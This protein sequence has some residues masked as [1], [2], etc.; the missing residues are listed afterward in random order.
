MRGGGESPVRPE[1]G[2]GK[3]E[4]CAEQTAWSM[5]AAIQKKEQAGGCGGGE[6]PLGCEDAENGEEEPGMPEERGLEVFVAHQEELLHMSLVGISA[7]LI[8]FLLL[9]VRGNLSF[10]ILFLPRHS[11]LQDIYTA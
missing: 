9:P 7:S 3:D 1:A 6:K 5:Q 2:E 8:T 11:Y 4:A 10:N